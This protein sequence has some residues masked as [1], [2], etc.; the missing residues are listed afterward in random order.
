MAEKITPISIIKSSLITAFTIA[1][2]L[3]WKDFIS[4]FITQFVPERQELFYE[5]LVAVFATIIVIIA[6][7]VI[8]KTESEAET[9]IKNMKKKR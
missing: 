7:Y 1:A 2:A 3:I 8:I 9:I 5:F 6:I 4:S